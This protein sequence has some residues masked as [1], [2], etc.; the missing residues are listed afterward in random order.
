MN[1]AAPPATAE[2]EQLLQLVARRTGLDFDGSHRARMTQGILRLA[3]AAGT[4]DHQAIFRL[5]T[6]DSATLD[7]LVDHLTVGE[8]YFFREP[9]HLDLIRTTIAPRLRAAGRPVRVWSAGC[10]TGEE[11]YS[12]AILLE[13]LA[14]LDHATIVGTD[15][16]PAALTTARAGVYSPW[17]LRRCSPEEQRRWFTHV[18][19]RFQLHDRYRST[20]RFEQRNLMEGPPSGA[21]DV[22]LCRNVL[23]YLTRD[24]ISAAA[25]ALH[26]ALAPD[27]WLLVGASDPPLPHAG[28]RRI[29][30]PHGIAYRRETALPTAA[31]RP[32]PPRLPDTRSRTPHRSSPPAP[33]RA[34]AR[35]GARSSAGTAPSPTASPATPT[36][37]AGVGEDLRA[38]IRRVGAR[39]DVEHA[40]ALATAAVTAAPLD[41]ELR[42]T[43]AIVQL[44]AGWTAEALRE[45]SAAVYLDPKLVVAHLLMGQAHQG[46]GR[47]DLAH[48]CQR[49]AVQ[50]LAACP[51]DATVP[52]TDGE[53]AGDLRAALAS[54]P[55][56][57]AVR[58]QP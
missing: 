15:V 26:D 1:L 17:S 28:L 9:G 27:G 56:D 6:H 49:T 43:A 16:S 40:I 37:A 25:A 35:P 44:D 22:V 21:F 3:D 11:P 36:S 12:I 55:A 58:V 31:E 5:A 2:V 34:P 24:G 4:F 51:S 8:T 7:A 41:A 32:P 50:L 53:R 52:L 14:M 42:V 48:Q 33:T 57:R 19:R 54:E 20:V 10:A 45:A 30:G 13:A 46:L 23:I 29:I 47:P 39:G 18:G 38:E